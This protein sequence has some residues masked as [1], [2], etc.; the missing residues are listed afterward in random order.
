MLTG[1]SLTVKGTQLAYL[2][3]DSLL[4][5][6]SNSYHNPMSYDKYMEA[7]GITETDDA[8]TVKEK[9]KIFAKEA[10]KMNT[11]AKTLGNK[12]L[13]QIG[14]DTDE[15]IKTVFYSDGSSDGGGFVYFY[16]NFTNEK[17]ASEFMQN[18]YNN[19]PSL[20]EAMNGYL[21][22]YFSGEVQVFL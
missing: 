9:I 16:L 1:E 4:Q 14:V 8:A 6:E 15:P 11:A 3:P 2:V 22:F 7:A 19:N 18:Y 10:V 13:S 21:S 12:T 5:K 17:K 20:K